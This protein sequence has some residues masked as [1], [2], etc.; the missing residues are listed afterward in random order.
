[1]VAFITG[2][3]NLD[4]EWDSYVETIKSIA[5]DDYLALYQEAY[6]ASAF[7]AK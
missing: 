6:D 3:M 5:L 7:A 1:M 2:D 4:T